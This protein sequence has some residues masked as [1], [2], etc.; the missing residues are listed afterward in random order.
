MLPTPPPW[1][2]ASLQPFDLQKLELPVRELLTRL[3]APSPTSKSS[4]VLAAFLLARVYQYCFLT[5][6][7]VSLRP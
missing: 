2:L 6:L 7:A 3:L 4:L 1:F 5:V